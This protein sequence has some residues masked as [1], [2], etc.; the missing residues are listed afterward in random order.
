MYCHA[1]HKGVG[2]KGDTNVGSLIVKSVRGIKLQRDN[3]VGGELNII[4]DNCSG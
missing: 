2:K 1:Y 4:F 3:D